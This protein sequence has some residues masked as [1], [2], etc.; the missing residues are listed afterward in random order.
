M[1]EMY[2]TLQYKVTEIKFINTDCKLRYKKL[3]VKSVQTSK[4]HCIFI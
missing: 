2:V 3:V 4:I 1:T